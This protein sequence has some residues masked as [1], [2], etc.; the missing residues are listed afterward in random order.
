MRVEPYHAAH[1]ELWNA[2]VGKS[3]NG[4]FMFRRGYLDYHADRFSNESVIV[5]DD[6]DVPIALFPASRHDDAIVSHGGL[7]Y[8]GVISDRAMRVTTMLDVFVA[9]ISHYR[10]AGAQ[11]L[12]YKAIPHIYHALPAEED[13]YALFRN[14]ARLVRRDVSSTVLLSDRLPYSKG[15]SHCVKKFA[16]SGLVVERSFDFHGFMALEAAH[17]EAKFGVAPVHSGDE[18]MLLASRFPDNV[19]LFVVQ[20]DPMRAGIVVYESDHVAH[21]QY[22][23]STDEGRDAS[24]VDGII[25]HLLTVVYPDKRYFDFGISTEQAGRYLNAGLA[26][27]KETYGARTTV[28]DTYELPLVG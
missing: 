20:G 4:N 14:D 18:M 23:A 19:K 15:R 24:A 21:A 13:L 6:A 17:L 7:T 1:A 25:E 3:K 10:E 11:R 2:Y 27:N 8:G 28:Y 9:L 16:K 5:L 26:G 22:I 12:I